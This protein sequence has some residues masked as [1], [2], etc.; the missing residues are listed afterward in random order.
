MTRVAEAGGHMGDLGKEGT[1]T[2]LD[3]SVGSAVAV[4][5]WVFAGL[6][7]MAGSVVSLVEPGHSWL[8]MILLA[9]GIFMAAG[10]GTLTIRECTRKNR[11]VV[12]AAIQIMARE[13]SGDA[14]VSKLPGR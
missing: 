4:G 1:V 12:A 2:D 14:V 13:A 8:A 9:W 11:K 7:M 10:A 3:V 5:V 6:L